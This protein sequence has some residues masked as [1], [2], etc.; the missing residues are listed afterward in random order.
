MARFCS[1]VQALTHRNDDSGC[2]IRARVSEPVLTPDL[3]QA[4]GT[5]SDRTH[6]GVQFDGPCMALVQHLRAHRLI[7][8]RGGVRA[9]A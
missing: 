8:E 9:Y 7:H 2:A 6:L 5:Q 4:G 1:L 3:T